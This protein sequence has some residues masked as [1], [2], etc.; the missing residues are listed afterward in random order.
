MLKP[1]FG[2]QGRGIR[3]IRE[4]ADLPPPEEVNDVYY[5]QHNVPRAGPPFHDFRVFVR[6]EVYEAQAVVINALRKQQDAAGSIIKIARSL[7]DRD[8]A[9]EA[10]EM[11]KASKTTADG[12]AKNL[13]ELAVVIATEGTNGRS[14]SR[15]RTT[16]R[17]AAASRAGAK[18]RSSATARSGAT[19]RSSTA[20][21]GS[22]PKRGRST[23]QR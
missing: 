13:T 19:A 8:L 17:S 23:G 12:L 4:L 10:R 3:L 7:K 6:I 2:A 18:S 9:I 20:K 15:G 14:P 5:L 21:R 1:L 22:S 16:A 11:Q